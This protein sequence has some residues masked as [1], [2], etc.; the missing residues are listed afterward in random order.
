[1]KLTDGEQVLRTLN[2]EAELCVRLA[3]LRARQRQL[4]DAGEAEPLLDV[5]ADKQQAIAQVGRIENQLRPLKADWTERRR[6]FRPAQRVAIGDALS[7]VR[8]LLEELI[9]RETEDAEAL[10]ARK[11]EVADELQQ[12]DCKRRLGTAYGAAAVGRPESRLVDRRDV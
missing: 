4:I 5:L 7:R 9:A 3:E 2:E 12:F 6:H 10:A 11:D 8:S 1:M